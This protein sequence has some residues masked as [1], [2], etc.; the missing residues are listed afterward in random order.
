MN[1]KRILLIGGTG[2][3]GVYLTELLLKQN[4]QVEVAAITSGEIQHP[5]LQS[6]ILDARDIGNLTRLLET[7]P[8]AVI[9]FLDYKP[10]EYRKRCEL[11]LRHTKKVEKVC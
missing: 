8:D 11:F 3:M 5:N 6:I 10:A 2:S 1:R 9:D 7:R 4:Y